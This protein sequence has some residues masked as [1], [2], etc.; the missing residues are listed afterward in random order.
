MWN[1]SSQGM[2]SP[3]ASWLVEVLCAPVSFP[4]SQQPEQNRKSE[5]CRQA[6]GQ[7][8]KSAQRGRGAHTRL[9]PSSSQH[10]HSSLEMGRGTS[11][12]E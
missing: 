11:S 1:G 3:F 6:D 10:I 5:P 9:E 4:T 2:Y 8:R 12:E 7:L